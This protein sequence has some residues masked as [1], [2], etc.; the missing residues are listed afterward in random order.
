VSEARPDDRAKAPYNQKSSVPEKCS[1]PSLIKKDGDD[2]FD[3]HRR[4]LKKLGADA[5]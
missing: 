5:T 1:W 3:H 2:L 4:T